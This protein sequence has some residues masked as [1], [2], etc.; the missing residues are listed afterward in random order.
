VTFASAPPALPAQLNLNDA[1]ASSGGVRNVPLV[2]FV[3][4]HAPEARHCSVFL[5]VQLKSAVSPAETLVES[6]LKVSVARPFLSSSELLGELLESSS[7]H[8]ARMMDKAIASG[9]S[10][11]R[12]SG[13][14][15]PSEISKRGYRDALAI[16]VN[17]FPESHIRNCASRMQLRHRVMRRTRSSSLRT[18]S[19]P[20]HF[21]RRVLKGNFLPKSVNQPHIPIGILR[22]VGTRARRSSDR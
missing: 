8:P 7:P 16:D 17:A 5:E 14:R 9:V 1:S 4:D 10:R 2:G 18:N 13:I 22:C 19:N 12:T 15:C 11:P 6:A 20:I 3:P 21:A